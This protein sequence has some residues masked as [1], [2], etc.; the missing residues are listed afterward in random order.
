MHILQLIEST[1]SSLKS[2]G[3]KEEP[4]QP[5]SPNLDALEKSD[6]METSYTD[7]PEEPK[8]L[9]AHKIAYHTFVQPC[10]KRPKTCKG[11]CHLQLI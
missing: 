6:Y 1:M 4:T 5:H 3:N 2:S 11:E 9:K 8:N 10:R 7:N